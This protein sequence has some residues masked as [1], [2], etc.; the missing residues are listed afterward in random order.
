MSNGLLSNTTAH[1]S[2]E[3]SSKQRSRVLVLCLLLVLGMMSLACMRSSG[4]A[5]ATT[6][7]R[8][9]VP[10][11]VIAAHLREHPLLLLGK[12]TPGTLANR[13]FL[14][15]VACSANEE[16]Q[17]DWIVQLSAPTELTVWIERGYAN[18]PNTPCG[19]T[20]E[21]ARRDLIAEPPA[22]H[23][24]AS[25]TVH[26]GQAEVLLEVAN[27]G[28]GERPPVGSPPSNWAPLRQPQ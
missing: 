16:L 20:P 13:G 19:I 28:T 26:P 5:T 4:P 8:I 25:A 21:A 7:V 27:N 14:L 24:H 9:R 15:A 6:R 22:W 2:E 3:S 1:R 23:P 11:A 12:Q 17:T 18:N 10:S